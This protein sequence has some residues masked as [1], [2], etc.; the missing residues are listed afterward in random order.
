MPTSDD[1]ELNKRIRE[2]E[3][4][5]AAE[6]EAGLSMAEWLTRRAKLQTILITFPDDTGDRVIEMQIPSWGAVCELTQMEAMMSTKKGHLRI[7]EILNDLC[8]T[9]SLDLAFWKSGAIGLIDMRHLIEGLTS[10]SLKSTQKVIESQTFR[11]D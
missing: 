5:E 11:K 9:P 2:R 10:E 6:V 8:M 4:N 1:P 3:A 7:A